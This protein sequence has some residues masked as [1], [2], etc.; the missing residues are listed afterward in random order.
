MVHSPPHPHIF[1]PFPPFRPPPS[2]F[3]S[4]LLRRIPHN[5]PLFPRVRKSRDCEE[6]VT[7]P[8]PA[9]VDQRDRFSP[10]F[11]GYFV[12][13]LKQRC[14]FVTFPAHNDDRK[15]HPAKPVR[16][17]RI[18]FWHCCRSERDGVLRPAENRHCQSNHKLW[19]ERGCDYVFFFK[20][21]F[22]S[23]WLFFFSFQKW[24]PRSSGLAVR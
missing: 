20:I 2:P 16:T 23:S 9:S 24:I 4:S 3:I 7:T 10:L 18:G 19:P 1:H 6:R 15:P 11:L 14:F 17:A 12:F 5:T 8:A 21:I 13:D 22:L